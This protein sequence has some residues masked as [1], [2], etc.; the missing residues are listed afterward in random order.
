MKL[1][2]SGAVLVGLPTATLL[3]LTTH[4]APCIMKLLQGVVKFHTGGDAAYLPTSPR[5]AQSCR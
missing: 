2:P 3:L 1:H 5:P 4:T